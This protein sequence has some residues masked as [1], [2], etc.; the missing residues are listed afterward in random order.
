MDRLLALE[1]FVAVVEGGSFR[2]GA[3]TLGITGSYASRVIARLEKRR[4]VRLL[5]RSSR[6]LRPTAAGDAYYIAVSDALH[7][8][9]EADDDLATLTSRKVGSLRVSLPTAVGMGLSK[10]LAE[11]QSAHPEIE[12]EIRYTD[13]FADLVGERI[14][15]ALRIGNLQDSSL[16][17]RRIGL[18]ALHIVGSPAYLDEFGRPKS[19]ADLARH[20]CLMYGHYSSPGSWK[21]SGPEGVIHA[22]VSGP[23]VSDSGQAL[24]EAAAT[25]LGLAQLPAFHLVGE[26]GAGRLEKVLEPFAGRL[27]VQLVRPPGHVTPAVRALEDCLIRCIRPAPWLE[28]VES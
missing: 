9:R 17:R 26:I 4:G 18:V 25:G 16:I 10:P 1:V 2:E 8:L 6:G 22:S 14:D 19:P 21:L 7:R 11:F 23:L 3:R 28:S 13:R 15:V 5:H 27:A 20:R 12:L 24:A